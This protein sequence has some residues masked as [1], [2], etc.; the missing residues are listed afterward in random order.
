MVW[1]NEQILRIIF[2]LFPSALVGMIAT[3]LD[4]NAPFRHVWNITQ[5]LE[6]Y[7]AQ[8]CLL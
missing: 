5:A 7:L 4:A 2:C 6:Y 8:V 1:T 3:P